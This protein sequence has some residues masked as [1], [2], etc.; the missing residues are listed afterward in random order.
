VFTH[1]VEA[2]KQTPTGPGGLLTEQ[3]LAAQW[4]T[5]ARHIRRLRV[6]SE[7][8]YIKL[9]RLV[10]FDPD[11]VAGWLAVHKTASVAS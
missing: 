8:P 3:E 9:G 4:H 1:G 11:D 10:R 6:E 7:L 5:T 2:N